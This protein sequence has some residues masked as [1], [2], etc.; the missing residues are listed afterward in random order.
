MIV[1]DK[2]EVIT[3]YL[4]CVLFYQIQLCSL[5]EIISSMI[6]DKHLLSFQEQLLCKIRIENVLQERGGQ[7]SVLSLQEL[8][9]L[10]L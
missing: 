10:L 5:G 4:L 1:I 7:D 2:L 8:L 6:D 3:H 9:Q